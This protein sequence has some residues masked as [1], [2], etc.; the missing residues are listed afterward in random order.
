[1]KTKK[2]K[3]KIA[4]WLF[5]GPALL[6]YTSVVIVPIICSLGFSFY[7]YSGVGKRV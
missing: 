2:S 7:D 5:S 3:K 6:A 4:P 1:M